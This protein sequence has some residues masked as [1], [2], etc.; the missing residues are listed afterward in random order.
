[1]ITIYLLIF[2]GILVA[3]ELAWAPAL[4]LGYSGNPDF[5]MVFLMGFLT[6]VFSDVMWYLFGRFVAEDKL[7]KIPFIGKRCNIAYWCSSFF[8]GRDKFVIFSSKFL[9]GTRVISQI[10]AGITRMNFFKYLSIILL[11][12][13]LWGVAILALIAI[14]GTSLQRVE[15]FTQDVQIGAI[16]FVIVILILNYGIRRFLER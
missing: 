15:D 16:I 8:N 7:S 5:W 1:M 9:Y 11:A 6:I 14:V 12:T 2:F 4:Y 13:L 10:L 3:G